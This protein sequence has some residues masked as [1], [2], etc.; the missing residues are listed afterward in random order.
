MS[1]PARTADRRAIARLEW[2]STFF[3][4]AIGRVDPPL[5]AGAARGVAADAAASGLDCVY[6][7][8][9]ASDVD[10]IQAAES[11]GFRLVDIR[12]TFAS[13]GPFHEPAPTL[14]SDVVVRGARPEDVPALEAIAREAHFD[15]RFH[16]DAGFGAAR[17][18]ALYAHWIAR[19]CANRDGEVFV[20]ERRGTISG[21]LACERD[22]EGAGRIALVAVS[23]AA[24][25][26]GLGLALVARGL[27][28]FQQA[29]VS[30]VRVVTQGRNVAAQRL[31]QRAGFRT[32]SADVWLHLWPTL[33]SGLH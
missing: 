25:G 4:L 32:E 15:G 20:L 27:A 23:D 22:D 7:R 33:A 11:A 26:Q 28:W 16:V 1:A 17:A 10:T 13:D 2:D 5:D 29:A 12:L 14:A 19:C 8:A 31:Y 18:S 6:L 30:R 9:A 21:Y 3:G 24:Q